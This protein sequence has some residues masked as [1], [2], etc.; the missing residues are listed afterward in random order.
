MLNTR[1][2]FDVGL[3]YWQAWRVFTQIRLSSCSW[4][5][6]KIRHFG[7]D[8]TFLQLLTVHG[9]MILEPCALKSKA[10]LAKSRG[11]L[12]NPGWGYES[13]LPQIINILC[14]YGAKPLAVL[15]VF[16]HW[17][18]EKDTIRFIKEGIDPGKWMD[19]SAV[20]CL[21][22]SGSRWLYVP[23]SIAGN[24]IW[25]SDSS[26]K[27]IGISKRIAS[28]GGCSQTRQFT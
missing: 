22:Y 5:H 9:L 3:T 2:S 4:V 17:K 27:Y 21:V 12:P 13:N 11:V 15:D 7:M 1:D 26:R 18:I 19:W 25:K 28:W 14:R 10:Q 23:Y 24:I 8:R 20:K 16:I 6:H